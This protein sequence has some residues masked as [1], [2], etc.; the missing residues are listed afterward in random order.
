M[1]ERRSHYERI[2]TPTE[3][4][5]LL[6]KF[7]EVSI[8]LNNKE[9]LTAFQLQIALEEH[10]ALVNTLLARGHLAELCQIRDEVWRNYVDKP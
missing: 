9:K 2:L 1:T 5:S 6:A 8:M 4:E 10:S 7:V 3:D